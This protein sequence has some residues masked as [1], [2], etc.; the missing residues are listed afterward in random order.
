MQ[1]AHGVHR[2]LEVAGL[3]RLLGHLGEQASVGSQRGLE[4][5]VQHRV[6]RRRIAA[7]GAGQPGGEGH[8]ADDDGEQL[9]LVQEQ[10]LHLHA[11]VHA[12]EED[13]EPLERRIRRPRIGNCGQQAWGQT[14]EQLPAARR[15]GR[16]DAAVVPA[17]DG[18]GDRGGLG[19]AHP[20][21]GL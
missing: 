15:S 3:A 8:D 21:Q 6:Q 13:R 9:G 14:G 5:R 11:R 1:A 20:L 19:K 12:G 18:V 2:A 17:A 10:R 16:G 7:E 4:T